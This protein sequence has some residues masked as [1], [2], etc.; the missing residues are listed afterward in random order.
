MPKAKSKPRTP[1]NLKSGITSFIP[2]PK[3]VVKVKVPQS[4]WSKLTSLQEKVKPVV[5]ALEKARIAREQA[6]AKEYVL[7]RDMKS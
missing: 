2:A 7:N 4:H 1:S 5:P 3:V 6:L